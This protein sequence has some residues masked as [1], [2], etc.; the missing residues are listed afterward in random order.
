MNGEFQGE[1]RYSRA[2]LPRFSKK[3]LFS[4]E[5][6]KLIV[7]E[8]IKIYRENGFAIEKFVTFLSS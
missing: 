8:K 7:L 5:K 2:S 1:N 3:F 6:N 4:Q